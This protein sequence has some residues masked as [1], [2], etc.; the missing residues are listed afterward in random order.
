MHSQSVILGNRRDAPSRCTA[1]DC[2]V[3]YKVWLKSDENC[4]SRVLTFCPTGLH[5]IEKEK[6]NRKKIEN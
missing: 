6:K 5:V 3:Y 4:R 2:L 1:T